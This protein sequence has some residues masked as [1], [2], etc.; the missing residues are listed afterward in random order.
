MINLSGLTKLTSAEVGT[1]SRN[2]NAV[3]GYIDFVNLAPAIVIDN[4]TGL[5]GCTKSERGWSG[6]KCRQQY[7]SLQ[8]RLREKQQ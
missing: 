5:T 4:M 3:N 7:L 1:Q 2:V 8:N 6:F